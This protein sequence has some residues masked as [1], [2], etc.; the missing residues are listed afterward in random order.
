MLLMDDS[1][2]FGS[3][4]VIQRKAFLLKLVLLFDGEDHPTGQHF[5][6]CF[7]SVWKKDLQLCH[8]INKR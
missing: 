6:A 7:L 5:D 1:D 3:W 2:F 4:R 8:E